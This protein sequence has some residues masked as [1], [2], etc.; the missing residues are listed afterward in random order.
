MFLVDQFEKII[1]HFV[2][3][4][5]L[6][7]TVLFTTFYQMEIALVA[8]KEEFVPEVNAVF[9]STHLMKSIHIQLQLK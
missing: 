9:V 7:L 1:L 5:I 4:L 8:L 6:L 3:G 2:P